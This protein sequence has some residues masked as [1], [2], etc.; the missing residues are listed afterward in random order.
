MRKGIAMTAVA[1]LVALAFFLPEWLSGLHDQQLLDSPSIQVRSGEQEGFAESL[2]M[3]IGEKVMLLRGGSM[4]VMELDHNWEET[5]YVILPGPAGDGVEFSVDYSDAFVGLIASSETDTA[6]YTEEL[7][8]LWEARLEELGNELRSLQAAGGLPELWSGDSELY[9]SGR[10][11]LLYIDPDT[12]MN[13]QVYRALLESDFYTME[14][15]ADVQ[16]GRILSFNLRWGRDAAPNWGIRGAYNFGGVWRNYWGLDS[17]SSGWY[18][19]Y[20]KSIL[21]QTEEAYRINGD[22]DAHGQIA[23]AYDGR[24]FSVP[25]DCEVH[26]GRSFSIGWN[27]F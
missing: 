17:V 18:N 27:I 24:T 11:D 8:Q 25:L 14:L 26:N 22:Y 5:A 19:A 15:T 3:P 16:S 1:A 13:F 9:C 20:N 23:F 7:S 12:K 10:G 4:T 6:S 21:E 2:Q